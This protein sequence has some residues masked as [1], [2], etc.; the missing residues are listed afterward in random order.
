M[1][2][3]L[4]VLLASPRSEACIKLYRQ[5]Q[6]EK[7][8]LQ[9]LAKIRT[10][11]WRQ[12]KRRMR[13][14]WL[15]PS[16]GLYPKLTSHTPLEFCSANITPTSTTPF[17]ITVTSLDGQI[18]GSFYGTRSQVYSSLALFLMTGRSGDTSRERSSRDSRRKVLS[19]LSS[20]MSPEV[21]STR[22]TSPQTESSERAT[23]PHVEFG[24][25]R[26]HSPDQDSSPPSMQDSPR[27]FD[28][29]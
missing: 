9:S 15:S 25:V 20:E 27:Y 10:Q 21:T 16:H 1:I 8:V 6:N 12:D 22:S 26:H 13:R 17:Q 19:L 4:R 28:H 14:E 11:E 3:E 2:L 18:K 5:H 29:L 7:F 24:P 23:L